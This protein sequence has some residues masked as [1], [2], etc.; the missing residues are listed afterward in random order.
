MISAHCWYFDSHLTFVHIQIVGLFFNKNNCFTCFLSVVAAAEYQEEAAE[1]AVSG[2]CLFTCFLLYFF[3]FNF[4]KVVL[5]SVTL[6][7]VSGHWTCW[8]LLCWHVISSRSFLKT[9]KVWLC[10]DMGALRSHCNIFTL[11]LFQKKMMCKRSELNF[12]SQVS[13][14][15]QHI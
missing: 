4:L 5:T 13:V 8:S 6:K 11:T 12:Q 14:C 1:P 2:Q 3:E 15:Q 7:A 9:L 10:K